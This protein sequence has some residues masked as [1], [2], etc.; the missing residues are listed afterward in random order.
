MG[1][2]AEAVSRSCALAEQLDTSRH[3]RPIESSTAI[4]GEAA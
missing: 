4:P 3:A 2:A 1:V